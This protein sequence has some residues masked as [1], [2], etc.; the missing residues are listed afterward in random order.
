MPGAG[1]VCARV[2]SRGLAALLLLLF[3]F[4]A[5]AELKPLRFGLWPYHSPRHLALYY[6]D[7]G[8]HLQARLGRDLILETAPSIDTFMQRLFRGEYD[9][10]LIGPHFARLAQTDYGWQPIAG[11][12]GGNPVYLVTLSQMDI[13]KASDLKGK[14]IATHDR[15]LLMSLKAEKWLRSQ[16]L[17]GKDYRWLEI[18]G[19]AG[20][21]YSLVS[22]E[23]D[24]AVATLASLALSPQEELSQLRIIGEIGSIP[25]LYI[26]ASPALKA[27]QVQD[28]R[29]ACR[30]FVH[31][32]QRVLADI[33]VKELRS[34]DEFVPEIRQQ[35][36]LPGQ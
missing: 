26:F 15:T 32:G 8:R 29:E 18:G 16:G 23:A 1:A 35:L 17:S 24:A 20:S 14:T 19:V 4:P 21:V 6:D 13:H 3:A 10:A 7:L 33:S 9:I 34:M 36:R 5:W 2:F 28:M 22:G 25:Q 12:K 27:R 11:Y 30:D 31:E